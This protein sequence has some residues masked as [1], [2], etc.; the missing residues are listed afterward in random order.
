MWLGLALG[1]LGAIA[2]FFMFAVGFSLYNHITIKEF[3]TDIFLGVQD[4]QS[5]IVTFSM[6]VDVVMFFILMK[7]NYFNLCKGIM[8][9]M[10]V[11]VAVVAMLY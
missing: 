3:I 10:V 8:A 6:L 11:S 4:F 7:K 2:G 9:V 1:V 5:R